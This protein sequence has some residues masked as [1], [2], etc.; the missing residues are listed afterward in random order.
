MILNIVEKE[1]NEHWD[2][3]NR[4][5]KDKI[6]IGWWLWR[7][8]GDY[9]QNV[10]ENPAIQIWCYSH[11]SIWN[12]PNLFSVTGRNNIRSTVLHAPC[13]SYSCC[14]LP[15]CPSP[16][17][18][19]D[20]YQEEKETPMESLMPTIPHHAAPLNLQFSMFFAAHKPA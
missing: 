10:E 19:P 15:F 16:Y 1:W 2:T 5:F 7:T 8:N 13:C 4:Y 3:R 18:F 6:K 11:S 9:N 14:F 20:P 12:W 17:H